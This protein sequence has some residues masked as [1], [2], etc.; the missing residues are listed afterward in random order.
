MKPKLSIIIPIC[1]SDYPT[2]HYTGNCI[3]SIRYFSTTE[4]KE[5]IVID[6][7]SKAT[8]GHLYWEEYVQKY[9]KNETNRG[10][11]KAWNQGIEAAE[12]EYL[13]FVNSDVEVYNRWDKF[14][15][16]DLNDGVGL[17]MA[18]PMYAHPFGRAKEAEELE[19]KVEGDYLSDFRDFSCFMMKRETIDKLGKFDENYGLGWGEDI[20]YAFRI[21]QAGLTV[22]S[23]Q[24]VNTHHIGMASAYALGTLINVSEEMDRNKEYT[25][26]KW[27]LDEFNTPKFMRENA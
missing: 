6:N 4:D 8:L 16:D 12:G 14:L 26:K 9:I 17:A 20:D 11:S 3:G 5:I 19:G 10:V 18:S 24:R 27:E 25:A 7:D 15:I 21:L 22:K 23:D 1:N 13:A 2:C